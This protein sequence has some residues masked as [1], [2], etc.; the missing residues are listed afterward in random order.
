MKKVFLIV[1]SY[2]LNDEPVIRNRL[3][4]FIHVAK[5]Q[6]YAVTLISPDK[7]SF[8]DLEENFHHIITPDT[9]TKPLSYIKR[10]L[11]EYRQSRRLF[12][13][14][15]EVESDI[16]MVTVP[17]LMLLFNFKPL[18]K[19]KLIFDIRDLVWEYIPKKGLLNKATRFIFK[20][21]ARISLKKADLVT[22]TN[23]YEQ[24]YLQQ[25]ITSWAG[26]V[27]HV[28]NGVSAEQ[29]EK[30]SKTQIS[31]NKAG[32]PTVAYI[33]NVGIA[34]D[35]KCL[36]DVADKMPSVNFIVIGEGTNFNFLKEYIYNK[37]ILNISLLGR[38][39][40]EEVLNI[41]NSVDILYAQLTADFS[42]AVPSKLYEYLST[43][44]Y[45][46]YGGDKQAEAILSKFT[47]N[48]V[49]PPCDRYSLEKSITQVIKEGKYL[50]INDENKSKVKR[51]FIREKSV[52]KVFDYFEK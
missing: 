43:G 12:N 33:G 47:H 52:A 23:P 1:T 44:K 21:L 5:L 25:F 13:L 41:Y 42:T 28:S 14:A 30:L 11:F 50:Q 35:L 31:R 20:H 29:Y 37:K 32:S 38:L 6:G 4:P 18:Y 15:L 2:P 16:C 40:W 27:L 9:K 24:S 51:E 36:A 39:P 22:T 26:K 46:I 3:L 19:A 48:I 8:T 7:S 45:I 10:A 17:S 34:Q 49:I